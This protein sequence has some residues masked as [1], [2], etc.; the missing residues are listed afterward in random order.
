MRRRDGDVRTA[1]ETAL[2]IAPE[3]LTRNDDDPE[4][5]DLGVTVATGPS[6]GEIIVD[7]DGTLIYTPFDGFSGKDSFTYLADDGE[8]TSQ[9]ATVTVTVDPE[10]GESPITVTLFDART[11]APIGAVTPGGEVVAPVTQNMSDLTLSVEALDPAFDGSVRLQLVAA[12]E[13]GEPSGRPFVTR[14]ENAGPY[15]LYGDGGGDFGLGDGLLPGNYVLRTTFFEADRGKGDVLD[16]IDTSFTLS[17]GPT[18]PP[19]GLEGVANIQFI[20]TENDEILETVLDTDDS[21][22]FEPMGAPAEILGLAVDPLIDGVESVQTTLFDADGDIVAQRL[23]S[24]APYA[25]FGDRGGDFGAPR[26]LVLVS[27]AY[28]LEVRLFADNR[29]RELL[30]AATIEFEIL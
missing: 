13:A 3:T 6:N 21:F 8:L 25:L 11:D 30:D 15:T 1:F 4:G 12:N 20:D 22:V 18:Q 10:P 19:V 9:P 16:V 24:V 26:E 5:S 27:G 23:E 2:P 28:E 7:E 29:G 14:L 17:G